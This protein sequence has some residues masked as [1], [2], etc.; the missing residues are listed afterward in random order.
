MSRRVATLLAI[1]AV[2][3]PLGIARAAT[4][5]RPQDNFAVARATVDGQQQWDFAWSIERRR[6][7][8]VDNE[9]HAIATTNCASCQAVA[10]AF[11]IVLVSG[12]PDTVT[13]KNIAEAVNS[14]S[15]SAI[16]FAD[17]RQFVWVTDKPVHFTGGG[18][19]ELAD[20]RRDIRALQSEPLTLDQLRAKLDADRARV[21]DV[22]RQDL[23]TVRD[24]S[25]DW[26]RTA[27]RDSS[28][29]ARG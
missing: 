2:G 25:R 24:N 29:D 4:A 9:N 1:V 27:R 10:I 26:R 7:G 23:V 20:V 6:G 15:Q 14:G 12:S 19:H 21:L 13:P 3:A 16:S 28:R 5:P 22:L 8:T 18:R 17:A 11:Q